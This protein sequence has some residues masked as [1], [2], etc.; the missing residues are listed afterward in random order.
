MA[1]WDTELGTGMDYLTM[2][3]LGRLVLDNF[4]NI[5][6]SYVTQGPKMAQIALRFGAND[7]GSLMIEE[8]VVSA[9]GIDFIMPESEI[10]RLIE[11]AGFIPRRRYQNYQYCDDADDG[12]ACCAWRTAAAVEA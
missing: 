7:F 10:V 3:A 5:Q 4:D 2:T 6:V 11:D 12:C 8:N 9:T 1:S